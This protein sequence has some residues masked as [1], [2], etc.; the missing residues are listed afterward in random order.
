MKIKNKRELQN[1]AIKHSA[2]I[3]YKDFTKIF[4]KCAAEPHSFLIDYTILPTILQ[5]FTFMKNYFIKIVKM[6]LTD[7]IK[8]LNDKIKAN[9]TQYN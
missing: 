4:I 2:E 9:Q 5:S 7:E 1:I 8:I 6:T 3:H